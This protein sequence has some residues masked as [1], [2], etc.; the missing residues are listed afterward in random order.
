MPISRL[1]ERMECHMAMDPAQHRG[2]REVGY[3]PNTHLGVW[4]PA[5]GLGNENF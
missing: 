5:S 2:C 1:G 3:R 4:E